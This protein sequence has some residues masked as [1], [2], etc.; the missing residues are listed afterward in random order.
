MWKQQLALWRGGRRP[1]AGLV[2]T[3]P[4]AALGREGPLWWPLP[5]TRPAAPQSGGAPPPPENRLP[6][7]PGGLQ[8]EAI[9]HNGDK[10]TG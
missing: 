4:A 6:G 8:A 10:E 1:G 7:S 5:G 9:E 3:P 2:P